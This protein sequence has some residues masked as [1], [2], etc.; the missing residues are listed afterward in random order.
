MA[1]DEA[2]KK[3]DSLKPL[4][5]KFRT[6]QAACYETLEE[7]MLVMG[8]GI[9]R[10]QQYRDLEGTF[11]TLWAAR[12]GNIGYRFD[13]TKDRAQMLRLIK[14]MPLE[15]IKA[16][17]ARYVRSNDQFFVQCKHAFPIFIKTINQHVI[18]QPTGEFSLDAPTGCT[19]EPPCLSDAAHTKKINDERRQS[20]F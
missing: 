19:H 9:T 12:Y 13:Y 14:A 18:E 1:K 17:M 3:L 7:I 16:R 6:Q 5:E 2:Q 4:I 20:A 8:G 11:S 15:E 10:A